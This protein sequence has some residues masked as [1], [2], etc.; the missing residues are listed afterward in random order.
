MRT[1]ALPRLEASNRWPSRLFNWRELTAF[2]LFDFYGAAGWAEGGQ[3]S[4]QMSVISVF[5]MA[6]LAA[7]L[8]A[9]FMIRR[10]SSIWRVPGT[11]S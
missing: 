7:L 8:S 6:P 4:H 2:V 11:A 5:I 1:V 3:I 10:T 9:G